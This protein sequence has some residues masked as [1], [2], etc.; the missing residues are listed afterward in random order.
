MLA[1]VG[2]ATGVGS[3]GLVAM[4]MVL[5]VDDDEDIRE[6]LRAILEDEGFDVKVARDGSDALA[7]LRDG[8]RPDVIVL[9]L[10]MPVMSGW[11]FRSAQRED[12]SLSGIP[13]VVLSATYEQPEDLAVAASLRKPIDIDRLLEVVARAAA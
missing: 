5:L 2:G 11:Q 7:T 9:D 13:V 8:L 10:M 3:A 4:K 12:P 6:A 1:R